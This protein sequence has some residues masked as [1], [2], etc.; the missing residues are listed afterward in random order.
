MT[1]LDNDGTLVL[2]K[3]MGLPVTRENYIRAAF[4]G[5][6]PDEL[7]GEIEAELPE[8]LQLH[9][10]RLFLTDDDR[11]LMQEIGIDTEGA[12]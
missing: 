3:R 7:D 12:R 11:K 5:N 2:L 1:T 10:D 9:E 8:E 6:P 4:L